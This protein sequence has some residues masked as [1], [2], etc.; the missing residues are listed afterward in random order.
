[1]E[2]DSGDD[3]SAPPS[4]LQPVFEAM[5][6][7]AHDVELASKQEKDGSGKADASMT[8]LGFDIRSLLKF[9]EDNSFSSR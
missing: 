9:L 1:M 3:S 6:V 8:L 5:P 4:P 7:L 2:I